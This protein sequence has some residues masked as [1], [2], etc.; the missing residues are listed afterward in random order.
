MKKKILLMSAI[1]LVF[2]VGMLTSMDVKAENSA[3]YNYI[4]VDS[5]ATI[6]RYNGSATEVVIPRKIDG[7]RV[8]GIG[9][10]AFYNN[11]KVV[12]ITV[13]YGV[14]YID[15]N[16]F[17]ECDNLE[18]ISL[19]D[20]V[21]RIGEGTF[22]ACPKLK[23]IRIPFK[24][25]KLEPY[26]FAECKS[27]K[28]VELP[29]GLKSIEEG[30]FDTCP[31]LADIYYLGTKQEWSNITIDDDT[32]CYAQRHYE[33][34]R[35][36]VTRVKSLRITT[37]RKSLSAGKSLKLKVSILPSNAY[38]KNLIWK[39]SNDKYAK[40]SKKGTVTAKKAGK[41][42]TVTIRAYTKD[43]SRLKASI[44]LKIK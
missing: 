19:P 33:G 27:L 42:K 29:K 25:T 30:V 16:V 18:S 38:N 32:I 13:P 9:Q 22:W 11:D 23:S 41:R 6:T 24:V 5:E 3:D 40:V 44:K 36:R 2:G 26:T 43:G 21:E 28:S 12:S 14:S 4:L 34:S 10:G 15:K 17:W 37:Q 8:K 35:K 31:K 20:T 7:Y 1:I 39:S